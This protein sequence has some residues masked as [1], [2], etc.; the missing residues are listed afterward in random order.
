[1]KANGKNSVEK[2]KLTQEKEERMLKWGDGILG[3]QC[4]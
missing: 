2:E 3:I 1:M 4:L